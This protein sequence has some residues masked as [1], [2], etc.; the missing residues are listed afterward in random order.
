MLAFKEL[1]RLFY[2]QELHLKGISLKEIFNNLASL[3]RTRVLALAFT[4]LGLVFTLIFGVGTAMAPSYTTLYNNLSAATASQVVTTLEQAGFKVQLSGGGSIISVP[5]DQIP[6][7]RMA[8]ADNGLPNEGNPGWELFDQASGLGMN[9]F[10]QKINRLRAL[11]GELARSIQSLSTVEAARVHLVLPE[12]EAFSRS[13]PS[14]SASVIVRSRSN[15]QISRRQALS[16]RALVAAAVPEMAPDQVTVISSN[17]EAI[18]VEGNASSGKTT[19]ATV[20]VAIEDRLSSNIANILTARVGA[21]NARVQVA[22]SLNHERRVTTAQSFDPDQQVVR[23][24]ESS[25][26]TSS[27]G[28]STNGSVDVAG[29][30]PGGLGLDEGASSSE[31]AI[32]REVVNYEIGTT[33]TEIVREAG[34]IERISVAVLING[35]RSVDN[36]GNVTYEERSKEELDRL[37]QLIMSASGINLERGDSVSVDSL[38]FMDYNNDLSEPVGLSYGQIFSENIGSALRGL[39]ALGLIA[40]VLILG[41]RPMLK[42]MLETPQNITEPAL[43]DTSTP[44]GALPTNPTMKLAPENNPTVMSKVDPLTGIA[45]NTLPPLISANGSLERQR[46]NAFTNIVEQEPVESMRIINHWLAERA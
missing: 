25:E 34:E 5:Q 40:A 42:L 44:Q 27:D 38:R 9:S 36:D 24:T 13:R 22:V 12:R 31:S 41:V 10:M 30:L 1:I 33:N 15:A 3:G 16:I 26:E 2:I 28:E 37:R 11:E 6:R 18:L 39:F 4:G 14:P 29:N 8:L 17:G 21:G 20:K 45:E 43:L 7:A 46:I 32:T 19:L 35:A 23:S